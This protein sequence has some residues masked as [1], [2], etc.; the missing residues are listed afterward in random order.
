MPPILIDCG[1]IGNARSGLG[2]VAI[3]YARA[4]IPAASGEFAVRILAHSRFGE[5]RQAAAGAECVSPRFTAAGAIMRM[6]NKEY[7]RHAYTKTDH[8]LRH[9]IHRNHYEIPKADDAPLVLT[10]HDMHFMH[11][12]ENRKRREQTAPTLKRLQ[13]SANR[14]SVIGFISE[15]ARA[16]AAAHLDFGDAE[17]VIIHNGVNKPANPQKPEW[18]SQLPSSG[19]SR[20]GGNRPFL[21]SVA[22]IV[23]HKNYITMPPIMRHLPQ[24]DLILAGR[25][26]KYHAPQIE[27]SARAEKVADRVILPGIIS[28]SEK[29]WLLQ[30]CAGFVFPSM[31]EGFGMPIIEAMH[32]G[33][34]VFCF[35]N[36]ALPEIGGDAAYYWRDDS[37]KAMAE[38]IQTTLANETE[39]NKL[40]RQQWAAKFNWQNNAKEYIKIYRKLLNN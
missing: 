18:Y 31:R 29:A 16:A 37:P 15:Y 11:D 6:F 7:R 24:M 25:K 12:Y 19:H 30:H 3:Q 33:K 13:Q 35:A 14:A 5:I 26:K 2:Q 9:A 4:L 34:P 27:Q 28:E 23:P 38:L 21:L 39:N 17:Q 32:F 40:T 10:I 8:A 36:T 20:E 1:H 22:Q